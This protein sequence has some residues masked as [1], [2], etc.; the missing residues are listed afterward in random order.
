MTATRVHSIVRRLMNQHKKAAVGSADWESITGEKVV[1]DGV[2]VQ[3]IPSKEECRLSFEHWLRTETSST[4][5]QRSGEGYERY[6][7]DLAWRAWLRS[8]GRS[9]FV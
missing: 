2:I 7:I 9:E 6:E 5:H 3:M 4:N 1:G 8:C